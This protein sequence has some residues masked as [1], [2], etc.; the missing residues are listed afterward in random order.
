MD[1]VYQ[2]TNLKGMA[3]FET[4]RDSQRT[5]IDPFMEIFSDEL[6][7]FGRELNVL[8]FKIEDIWSVQYKRGDFHAVHTHGTCNFSGVLYLDYDEVEHTPTHFVMQ[9]INPVTNMTD[10]VSP[11]VRE[12]DI[13]IFPSN[14]LHFT[15]PCKTDKIRKIISFDITT[16]RRAVI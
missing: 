11:L 8:S 13:I 14:I 12:G 15:T 9:N 6:Q 4:D 7:Q 1:G 3:D 10:I 5:Y 16:S 2:R